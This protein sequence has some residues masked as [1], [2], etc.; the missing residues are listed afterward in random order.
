MLKHTGFS[1][2]LNLLTGLVLS[3]S[4]IIFSISFAEL[5]FS[6]RAAADLPIGLYPILAGAIISVLITSL[7]SSLPIA[8]S[9]PQ[10]EPLPIIV[11][12][13]AA[14]AGN[15]STA[16]IFP[17]IIMILAISTLFTGLC[18]FILGVFKLGNLIRYVPFPVVVGFLASVGWLL[19][20][21]TIKKI[22]PMPMHLHALSLL[23]EV[24]HLLLWLPVVLYAVIMLI[25]TSRYQ[26][27]FILP[28]LLF[29][30]ILLFYVIVLVANVP[31]ALLKEQGF[32]FNAFHEKQVGHYLQVF[33]LREVY[34]GMLAGQIKNIMAIALISILSLL[35]IATSL[36]LGLKEE[37]NFDKELRTAGMANILTGLAG[38][39]PAYLGLIT[40]L[41]NKEME[42]KGRLTGIFCGLFSLLAFFYST[43]IISYLPRIVVLGLLLFLG[44]SIVKKWIVDIRNRLTAADYGIIFTIL[45][46]VAI[47]G[48]LQGVVVGIFLSIILFVIQYSRISTVKYLLTGKAL[49]SNK[50]RDEGADRLLVKHGDEILYFKLQNYLFFG[51]AHA[52]SDYLQRLLKQEK[53][54]INFV[55]Y[56]FERVLAVDSSISSSFEKIKQYAL[57][58]K[59]II[60]LTELNNNIKNKLMRN[61]IIQK[62]DPVLKVIS[63]SDKALEWCEE[64]I[65]LREHYKTRP[66]FSLSA[67]LLELLHD[68]K[69]AENLAQY[70]VKIKLKKGDYLFHR[71]DLAKD[72]YYVESGQLAVLLV[73]NNKSTRRILTV[74]PGNTI[75]EM[76][77][78]LDMPRSASILAEEDSVLGKLTAERLAK[79][80]EHDPMLALKFHKVII[81]ILARRLHYVNKQLQILFH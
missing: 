7:F 21:V 18:F 64:K 61:N 8:I 60:I 53:S 78:Y 71:G 32:L 41:L 43:A 42:S 49:H 76:G 54:L 70:F 52:L 26:Q 37:M 9:H 23:F 63:T 62:N 77:L 10:D 55:I 59:F 79:V 22:I 15:L 46:V 81:Q 6:G 38:G 31:F 4:I 39:I 51:T 68:K 69:S 74:G 80:I 28:L 35:L 14:I 5:I 67:Q 19:V 45:L 33:S 65:L 3:F 25:V 17:T 24:N 72:L 20:M 75:G 44:L 34:W 56:D 12:M 57:K 58:N 11:L 16:N 30:G 36:E 27:P 50:K 2:L 13:V 47:I 48:L 1:L 73:L 40:T 29:A 66:V